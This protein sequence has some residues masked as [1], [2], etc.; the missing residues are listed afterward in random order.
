MPAEHANLSSQ[1]D[2]LFA[3]ERIEASHTQKSDLPHA[4]NRVDAGRDERRIAS[5]QPRV[6]VW[7]HPMARRKHDRLRTRSFPLVRECQS[8]QRQVP[9]AALDSAHPADLSEAA[10]DIEL[11]R[12]RRRV[13]EEADIRPPLASLHNPSD[14][15]QVGKERVHERAGPIAAEQV[16]GAEHRQLIG[17]AQERVVRDPAGI[18]IA[19]PKSVGPVADDAH[20]LATKIPVA[21]AGFGDVRRSAACRNT[22]EQRYIVRSHHRDANSAL[23]VVI[24]GHTHFGQKRLGA[25]DA[26]GFCAAHLCAR[27]THVE[28]EKAANDVRPCHCVNGGERARQRAPTPPE[29]GVVRRARPDV[30][31]A[32]D[33]AVAGTEDSCRVLRDHGTMWHSDTDADGHESTDVGAQWTQLPLPLRA[34]PVPWRARRSG[35]RS[36]AAHRIDTWPLDMVKRAAHPSTE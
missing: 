20:P 23:S 8:K 4:E 19:Q 24:R 14:A 34:V 18:S 11:R 5:N 1:S 2:V 3:A 7:A 12:Q 13:I 17:S 35:D 21:Y 26:L 28:R 22:A 27:P 36:E 32:H 10:A 30:D 15:L 29:A 33:A 16:A 31:R 25:E 9:E 6:G